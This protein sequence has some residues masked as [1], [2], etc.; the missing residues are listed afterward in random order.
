MITYYYQ[1]EVNYVSEKVILTVILSLALLL[2]SS[3]IKSATADAFDLEITEYFA[4]SLSIR[5]ERAVQAFNNLWAYLPKDGKGNLVY[6]DEYGG[7]YID[8]NHSEH[9]FPD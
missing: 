2:Y 8:D 9:R 3:Q 4:Q 7:E 5:Q 6:P 1:K